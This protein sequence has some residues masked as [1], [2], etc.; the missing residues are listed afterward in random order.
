MVETRSQPNPQGSKA[1][2]DVADQNTVEAGAGA[3]VAEAGV[4]EAGVTEGVS[5][6]KH[7]PLGPPAP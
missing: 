5:S 3:G 1:V 7:L 2:L 4:A 6:P